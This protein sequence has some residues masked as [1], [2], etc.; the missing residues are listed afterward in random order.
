[1]DHQQQ[2]VEAVMVWV[3]GALRKN[4][5]KPQ[6]LLFPAGQTI[7]T[8]MLELGISSAQPVVALV[9]GIA[10]DVHETLNPGDQIRLLPVISGGSL[11]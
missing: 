9:N 10:V 7:Y 11:Q 3:E 6:P 2:P 8:V 5:E 1:M 4:L